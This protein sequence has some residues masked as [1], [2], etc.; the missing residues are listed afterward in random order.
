VPVR[1]KRTLL[2]R[3]LV[4]WGERDQALSSR[5]LLTDLAEYVREVRVERLADAGHWVHR[6]L[7]ELVSRLAIDFLSSAP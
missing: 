1:A 2:Q 5:L 4:L 7:P 6:D 3:T